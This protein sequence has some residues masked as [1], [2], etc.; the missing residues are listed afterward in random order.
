[1][2]LLSTLCWQLNLVP[3]TAV[4]L[5]QGC[6]WVNLEKVSWHVSRRTKSGIWSQGLIS[7]VTQLLNTIASWF[8]VEISISRLARWLM[9]T[10]PTLPTSAL[11]SHSTWCQLFVFA[12]YTVPLPSSVLSR[13]HYYLFLRLLESEAFPQIFSLA[14]LKGLEE[15]WVF[16]SCLL[17]FQ[18]YHLLHMW[19]LRKLH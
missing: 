19:L 3:V 10:A 7:G 5:A 11:A 6:A 15:A 17:G 2:V 9:L 18:F 13:V 1:M 4:L 16:K 8:F 14:S 12:G